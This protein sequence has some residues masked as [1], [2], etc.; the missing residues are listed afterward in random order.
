[1]GTV[2]R[3]SSIE[4]LLSSLEQEQ[5]RERDSGRANSLI[6]A[7]IAYKSLMIIARENNS[8]AKRYN[9]LG[10]GRK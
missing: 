2:T 4:G 8:I 9:S 3:R 1:M 7:E 6:V 5:E 10:Y